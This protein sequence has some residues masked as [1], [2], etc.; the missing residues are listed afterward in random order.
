M[1]KSITIAIPKG[2]LGETTLE[3]LGE[4]GLPLEGVSTGSRRLYFSFPGEG[5]NYLIARA[6]DVPTYVEHG[7]ADLGIVGKDV[8]LEYRKAVVELLDLG[9]GPCHFALA[10]P[11]E[12]LGPDGFNI[13]RL[14]GKRVATKFPAVARE[15][16]E[17]RQVHT[18]IIKLY[19]N[20]ELA[21]RVGLAEAIIDLVSTGGTLRENGLV[22]VEEFFPSTARLIANR[23]SYNLKSV[24]LEPLVRGLKAECGRR[25]SHANTD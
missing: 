22:A 6:S 14:Q 12:A 17:Q 24:V 10:L 23:A 1:N 21:P 8:L 19:G 18:E 20:V 7:A 2:K 11:A 16:L 15:Y 13:Y 3:L 4:V 5:V 9:F 25:Y